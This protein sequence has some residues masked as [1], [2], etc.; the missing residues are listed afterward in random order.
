MLYVGKVK[1]PELI[2]GK[3]LRLMRGRELVIAGIGGG[4]ITISSEPESGCLCSNAVAT[5][6]ATAMEETCS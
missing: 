6:F 4:I 1:Q 3:I 2:S 5:W